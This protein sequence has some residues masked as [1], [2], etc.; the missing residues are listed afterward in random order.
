MSKST[1][2]KIFQANPDIKN[3][4]EKGRAQFG[5]EI[6]G[7]SAMIARS[8]NTH[9]KQAMTMVMFILK[10]QFGYNDKLQMEVINPGEIAQAIREQVGAMMGKP[11]KKPTDGK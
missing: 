2:Q 6:V 3:L 11:P 7:I 1:L 9:P 8:F 4:Y 10:T 5:Q